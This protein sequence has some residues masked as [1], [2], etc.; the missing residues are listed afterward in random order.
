MKNIKQQWL[1]AV[2]GAA[3]ITCNAFNAAGAPGIKDYQVTGPFLEIAP[4][5]ITVQKGD[6]RWV[7]H[8][9]KDTK[10]T[11]DLK[12]GAKVTIYYKMVAVEV[13]VK[14]AK[15]NK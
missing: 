13:K 3:L 8:R 7:V 5:A 6:E 1:L 14:E 10:I 15:D 2:C 9:E 4:N 11:G 12:I